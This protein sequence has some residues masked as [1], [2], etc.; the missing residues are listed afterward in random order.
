MS[1]VEPL[2]VTGFDQL[3]DQVATKTVQTNSVAREI[4]LQNQN[5]VLSRE[6]LALQ[7]G[8]RNIMNLLIMV[9]G[10]LHELSKDN[11]RHDFLAGAFGVDDCSIDMLESLDV[12]REIMLPSPRAPKGRSTGNDDAVAFASRLLAGNAGEPVVR[13]SAFPIEMS[14]REWRMVFQSLALSPYWLIKDNKMGNGHVSTALSGRGC[15][16]GGAGRCAASA[17]HDDLDLRTSSPPLNHQERRKKFKIKKQERSR[18][19]RYKDTYDGASSSPLTGSGHQGSSSDDSPDRSTR[20]KTRNKKAD[21]S[22]VQVL[23]NLRL[24]KEV[25]PPGVFDRRSGD[26]FKSFLS[27]FDRYYESKYTGDDRDKARHLGQYLGSEMKRWYDAIG[28]RNRRY[29]EVCRE[30]L[31]IYNSERLSTKEESYRKFQQIV[32]L[33]ADSMKMYTLRLEHA[34]QK[35]FPDVAEMERQLCRKLKETAPHAFQI[36]L[37]A[38]RSTLSMLGERKMSWQRMKLVADDFDRQTREVVVQR[39]LS[40]VWADQG[41]ILYSRPDPV[42]FVRNNMNERRTNEREPNKPSANLSSAPANQD[43]GYGT[44]DFYRQRGARPREQ[45]MN[46]GTRPPSPRDGSNGLF[47]DWCGRQGHSEELC[48]KK[49]GL[50]FLC[51]GSGHRKDTCPKYRSSRRQPKCSVCGGAHLGGTCSRPLDGVVDPALN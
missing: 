27:S 5:R 47:C 51:G 38:A 4:E 6:I 16:S 12:F 8:H 17:S 23:Q 19:N 46:R 3:S 31:D 11:V 24:P 42:G 21:L 10:L 18:R 13:D 1:D 50:C 22:L 14:F 32:V 30:L 39:D 9:Q 26:S 37:A 33:P 25:V 45:S 29:K 48:W 36:L 40:P 43:F 28:G 44:R 49:K 34:A 2:S 41:Q 15:S 35:A 20:H 7:D